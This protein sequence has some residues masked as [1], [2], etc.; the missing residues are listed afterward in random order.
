MKAYGNL[1]NRIQEGKN[2]AD[3]G[4]IHVGDDITMYYWSDRRCYY[5]TEV[6]DQKHIKVRE[7]EIV[8]DRSKDLDFGHQNWLYFKTNKECSDYLKEHN[9]MIESNEKYSDYPEEEW[10]FRYGKWRLKSTNSENSIV[11][12]NLGGPI[13][14][15]VRD[16]YYDWMF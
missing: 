6:I 4:L 16:Y 8:A 7:Y 14:F 5:V 9:L 13:S 12:Y 3:D 15:G 10:V 11:Y 1:I 2:Y